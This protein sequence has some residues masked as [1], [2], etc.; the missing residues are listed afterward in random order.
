[1]EKEIYGEMAISLEGKRV[2][3]K[4]LRREIAIR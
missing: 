1:M 3:R 4:E 2:D